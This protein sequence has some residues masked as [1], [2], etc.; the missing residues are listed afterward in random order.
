[1]NHE[2]ENMFILATCLFGMVWI[3]FASINDMML[4]IMTT[5]SIVSLFFFIRFR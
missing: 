1:M 5:L 2:S 3:F 4:L